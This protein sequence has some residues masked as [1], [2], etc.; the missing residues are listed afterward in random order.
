MVNTGR[1]DSAEKSSSAITGMGCVCA[2]GNNVGEVWASL[3]KGRV[4]CQH[5]PSW[6]FST[7]LD[8]PVFSG[9]RQSIQPAA[10]DYLHSYL[11]EFQA[12]LVSRTVLL[13]LSAAVE[14]LGQAGLDISYLRGKTVGIAL[15]TTVGCTFHN[16]TYYSAWRKGLAPDLAPVRYFLDGN[17]AAALHRI[18]GTSGPS[19]VVTN[20]CASGTDAIGLA[21]DWIA[22]GQCDIAIAG[23][24]DE[25]SRVAYNGFAS[26]L[27][28]DT[29]TC[30]PFSE[31]RKGLN[32]GEGAGVVI[33]ESGESAT[34][35]S[36]EISGWV[37]GYGAASDA[38]HP[39][40]PHPEG[41]GLKS[42]F[43]IAVRDAGIHAD[44]IILVNAHGTGTKANDIAETAAL[45]EILP[46]PQQVAIVSTKGITGHT[47]G[48]AGGIEAILTLMALREGST[49]GT[50]GCAGVDPAFRVKPLTQDQTTHL[51]GFIGAS[52]S[53]AFG[54]GNAVLILEAAG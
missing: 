28:S 47:L 22:G 51:N 17:I 42:A 35:R 39:T 34:G 45:A 5:P 26:L 48:A 27:L 52:Q 29:R 31:D 54:G 4:N 9:P 15:G 36:A 11:P 12:E 30:R 25:L 37:R 2:A 33:L 8:F 53:L 32:L 38:W 3:K 7:I 23:G 19:A 44:Q 40:A 1:S 6:L 21:K 24:A 16:E 14:G 50:I 10:R 41:R 13:A 46:D 20:A 49:P 18:L 43:S